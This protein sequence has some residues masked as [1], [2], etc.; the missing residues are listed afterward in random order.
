MVLNRPYEGRPPAGRRACSSL[1]RATRAKPPICASTR[2]DS[3]QD[4]AARIWVFCAAKGAAAG[5]VGL[6]P[7][8][9]EG[10]CRRRG[11]TRCLDDVPCWPAELSVAPRP[12]PPR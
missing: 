12:P 7:G 6:F 1:R 9:P 2:L 4:L 3:D 8:G 11:R 5:V 10:L